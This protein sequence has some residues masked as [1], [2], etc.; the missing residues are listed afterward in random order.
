M[1]TIM[2][3]IPQTPQGR[4][5]PELFG[6]LIGDFG[7]LL[8]SEARLARAETSEKFN[9]LTASLGMVIVGAVMLVPALVILLQ[10]IVDALVNAGINPVP[11]ALIVGGIVVLLGLALLVLGLRRFSPERLVPHRTIDQLERDA[12]V[13]KRQVRSVP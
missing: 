3:S 1:R 8:R 5:I 11:A 2:A 13:A 4:S 12:E 7:A 10:A 9:Q 6:D